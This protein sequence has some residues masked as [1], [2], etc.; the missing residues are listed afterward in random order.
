MDATRAA[1]AGMAAAQRD[2]AIAAQAMSGFAATNPDVQRV[3]VEALD[4]QRSAVASGPTSL[5][6]GR[7]NPPALESFRLPVGGSVSLD[8][9]LTQGFATDGLDVTQAATAVIVGRLAFQANRAAY[10]AAQSI[11]ETT[12][13]VGM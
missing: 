12:L 9:G 7:A 10:Q 6:N 2:V 5:D 13:K 4:A 8:P 3:K 11:F 1:A